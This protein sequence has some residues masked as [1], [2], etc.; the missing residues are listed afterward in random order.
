MFGTLGPKLCSLPKEDRTVYR[1]AYCGTCKALGDD[2][3][4]LARPLLSYDMVFVAAIIEATRSEESAH[5]TCRCPLLPVLQKPILSPESTSTKL[6]AALQVALAS[7]WFDDQVDD[8][9]VLFRPAQLLARGKAKCRQ[10]YGAFRTPVAP[11][12]VDGDHKRLQRIF[13]VVVVRRHLDR[14]DPHRPGVFI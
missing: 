1:R 2:Y 13:R 3:G 4:Q 14:V 7:A 5:E 10:R 9:S 12:N 8:G 6:A 11:Y